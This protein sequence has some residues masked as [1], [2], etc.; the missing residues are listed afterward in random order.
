[1]APHQN[2]PINVSIVPYRRP[3]QPDAPLR[4]Y[5]LPAGSFHAVRRVVHSG[6]G[7]R[8]SGFES[9]CVLMAGRKCQV[10]YPHFESDLINSINEIM[11][12]VDR[13]TRRTTTK[14]V[15]RFCP[16]PGAGTSTMRW[17]R[18]LDNR[19]FLNFSSRTRTQG[20]F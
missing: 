8:K 11:L 15:A 14:P 4:L 12:S 17:F 2:L 6:Q 13:F 9:H 3:T 18:N 16:T 1:M 20:N 5:C 19:T 7:L 10:S